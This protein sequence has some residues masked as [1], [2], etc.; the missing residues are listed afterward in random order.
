MKKKGKDV[1]EERE[2]KSIPSIYNSHALASLR[3]GLRQVYRA[4]D[5]SEKEADALVTRISVNLRILDHLYRQ[6]RE[7][8]SGDPMASVA[9]HRAIQ[10]LTERYPEFR[11]STQALLDRVG[12]PRP[13]RGALAVSGHGGPPFHGGFQSR[14]MMLPGRSL[15]PGRHGL[16]CATILYPGMATI[17]MSLWDIYILRRN[18]LTQPPVHDLHEALDTVVGLSL[19]HG[20]LEMLSGSLS[21]GGV[22]ALG[23]AVEREETLGNPYFRLEGNRG[24]HVPPLPMPGWPGGMPGPDGEPIPGHIFPPLPDECEILREACEGWLI[25]A[26]NTG[27]PAVPLPPPVIGW[28]NNIDE[29]ELLGQCAGD[30]IVIRGHGFGSPKPPTVHLIMKVNGVCTVVDVE[31]ANWSD[32]QITVTLPDGVTPG[33]VGFYDSE[34]A[35][36]ARNHYNSQVNLHNQAVRGVATASRC[37]GQPLDL[38]TFQPMPGGRVPCPPETDVNVIEVGLPII[39]SF[40]V[41]TDTASGSE[42][43]AAP[44]D[45]LVLRWNVEN[46]DTIEL[47]R[48][49]GDPPYGPSF[50]G[51]NTV[52]NLGGLSWDLG[53]ANHS[54][55]GVFTYQL[56]ATSPCGSV[57]A[58]VNVVGSQRPEISIQRIELTQSVQTSDHDVRLIRHKPTVVRVYGTH[59]LEGFGGLETV[60]NVTGRIRVRSGSFWSSW[61]SPVNGVQPNPPD[62][63]LPDPGASIEL[64]LDPDPT[65]TDDTLN[66]V[67]PEALCEGTMDIEVELRVDDF[68]APPG[69]PGFSERVSETF[70][71]FVTF[72]RRRRLKMRYIPATIVPDPNGNITINIIAGNPPTNAECRDF[73]METFKFLP[74]MPSSIQRLDGFGVTLNVD[75]T[76]INTPFGSF[77]ID[78]GWSESLI[79]D[80]EANAFTYLLGILR[81]CEF[82]SFAGVICTEDHDAYWAVLVPV[83][84]VWGRANGI[85]GREYIT[86]MV[87]GTAGHELAHCLNQHHLVGAGCSNG[88][89]PVANASEPTTDPANWTDGGQIPTDVAVPFDVIRNRTIT[90]STDGVWD[91]MTY[92]GTRWTTPQ[93]WQ[94]IFDFIGE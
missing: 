75:R 9:F 60:A 44:E 80:V 39:R 62:P 64:P 23:T 50:G 91:L 71:E 8:L 61:F 30:T 3:T 68:G 79:Y 4:R 85:P 35:E 40:T 47:R 42:I 45:E 86:P 65:Q 81:M 7:A 17:Y 90:N 46:A 66:F 10:S 82:F 41:A 25:D 36:V 67:I 5:R 38:P 19:G 63:P 20:H 31:P 24:G 55:I 56:T 58:R 70:E 92:C 18:D 16:P 37:L 22:A 84:G 21:H 34:Q 15:P 14:R 29:I 51:S 83:S 88:G 32:T 48:I 49:I 26:V 93:R 33:P 27:L 43:V 78:S 54:Q 12:I 94:M 11:G 87:A 13:A 72:R 59:G 28:A 73:L 89:S 57:Q 6:A 76:V 74:T 77:P 52:T 69:S 53:P 2:P 1:Q